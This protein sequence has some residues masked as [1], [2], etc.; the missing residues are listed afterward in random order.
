MS[1]RKTIFAQQKNYGLLL[2][3][4]FHGIFLENNFI[5]HQVKLEA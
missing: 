4:V 1:Q 3:I 2:E 5:S